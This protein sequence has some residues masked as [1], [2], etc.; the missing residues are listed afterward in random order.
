MFAERDLHV[1]ENLRTWWLSD[2]V[3]GYMCRY[4]GCRPPF[5]GEGSKFMD[6]DRPEIFGWDPGDFYLLRFN[7]P[8]VILVMVFTKAMR[9][10][11]QTASQSEFAVWLGSAVETPIQC[12]FTRLAFYASVSARNTDACLLASILYIGHVSVLSRA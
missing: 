5:E 2:R 4:V 3:F 9:C 12:F 11:M 1:L 8:H 7:K 6:G 10:V